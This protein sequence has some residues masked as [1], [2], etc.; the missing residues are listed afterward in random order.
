MCCTVQLDS[1][2][3]N[4]NRKYDIIFRDELP[5]NSWFWCEMGTYCSF[6][7]SHMNNQF[8]PFP[9]N[10]ATAINNASKYEWIYFWAL[11]LL[12]CVP[13]PS[14][15]NWVTIAYK[16]SWYLV[17]RTYPACP[18]SPYF[19]PKVICFLPLNLKI[20]LSDLG[21]TCFSWVS[22]SSTNWLRKKWHLVDTASFPP[23]AW[24]TF[25]LVLGSLLLNHKFLK[26]S[27]ICHIQILKHLLKDFHCKNHAR[28][29]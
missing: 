10:A 16:I 5:Q 24:N 21:K 26:I 8:C 11:Y 4:N 14:H 28:H 18:H 29:W 15:I 3:I 23:G 2:W 6:I 7:F 13:I 27:S 9:H 19:A 25:I 17:K 1:P 12:V 20:S 22:V